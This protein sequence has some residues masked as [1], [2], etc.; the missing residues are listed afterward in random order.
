MKKLCLIPIMILLF[1]LLACA[2]PAEKV[3]LVFSYHAEYS[4]V[5][6]ETKGAEDVLKEKGVQVEKFYLDTKRNTSAE[7]KQKM[8]GAAREGK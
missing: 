7:W 3:L 6:E 1:S 4:W 8:S 2:K 5:V